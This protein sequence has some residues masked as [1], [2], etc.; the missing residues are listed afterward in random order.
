MTNGNILNSWK[1]IATYV[2]RGVRTVQRWEHDLNLPVR[3][4]RGKQRSAVIALAEDLDL[5]LKTPHN[6]VRSLSDNR[7]SFHANHQRLLQNTHLLATQT[8]VLL[9]RSGTLQKEIERALT[10]ASELRSSCRAGRTERKDSQA[11]TNARRWEIAPSMKLGA[12]MVASD[13]P[14]G[15]TIFIRKLAR[16]QSAG[17]F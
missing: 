12:A 13:R 7:A 16:Q 1:E 15:G 5:W 11:T 14:G 4:P 2:G 3:R 8:T 9:A 17:S 6:G 10:I